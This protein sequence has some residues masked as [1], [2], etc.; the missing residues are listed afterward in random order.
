M[1]KFIT[2]AFTLS[3]PFALPLL[4]AKTIPVYDLEGLLSENGQGSPGLLDF[5]FNTDRPLTHFDIITSLQAASGDADVPGVVLEVDQA[6][7]SHAQIQEIARHL[8]KIREAGKD[9]WI[10]TDSLNTKTALLGNQSNHFVLMPE[11]NVS[12]TGFYSET[13][14]FKGLLDKVGVT[15]DVVHIGDFKS[16]GETYYRTGPSEPAKKQTEELYDG[17][18]E[19]MISSIT[20]GR[21]IEETTLTKLIDQGFI[22]PEEALENK[23]VDQLQHRTDFIAA[24]RDH[25]G[26]KARFDNSYELPDTNGPEIDGMMDLMRLMLSSGSD[27]KI[28]DPYIAVVVL[29]GGIDDTSIAPVRSQILKLKKD[30]NCKGLVFR[31]DSPGGS[32]LS[33]EVLWEATDEFKSTGKPFIVSMGGV[34][35]SGGYYVAAG[36]DHIFAEKGT[37]TGSIGVVGMKL[38]LGEAMN[39]FG[40]TTHEYKRGAHADIYN[41]NRPYTEAERE[42]VRKSMLDVYS[43]FKKRITDGRGEKLTDDLDKLAGGRVY[44]GTRALE[45]GLVDELGGLAEAIALAAEKA[46]LED[47]NTQ[48]LPEPS[49]GLDGLFSSGSEK[50]DDDEFIKINSPRKPLIDLRQQ[51]QTHPG[52]N[53]LPPRK[54]RALNQFFL[55]LESIQKDHIRLIAP[56][57]PF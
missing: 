2:A 36:A 5:G 47:P 4:N 7:F 19:Q 10:Y 39:Q 57:L 11:G 42:L 29:E 40:I 14:Y 24:V 34:A 26:K 9:V 1:K 20:S 54:K 44:L 18:F 38:A 37:I 43:T 16:F 45:I 51:I 53:L 52:L 3:L 27:K 31:I 22:T 25:Y 41:S 17:L 32:A 8:Q 46:E 30:K 48:L 6:G 56:A 28:R 13:M 15:A 21:K 33:S 23:L 50:E 35:A 12:L 49:A 55:D